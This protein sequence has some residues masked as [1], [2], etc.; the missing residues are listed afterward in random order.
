MASPS[1]D[2]HPL[3]VRTEWVWKQTIDAVTGRPVPPDFHIAHLAVAR[4]GG[5]QACAGSPRLY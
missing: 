3:A 1:H 2:R 5:R 4:K